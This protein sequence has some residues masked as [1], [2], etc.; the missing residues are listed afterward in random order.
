MISLPNG[1]LIP[2]DCGKNHTENYFPFE[3]AQEK[4]CETEEEELSESF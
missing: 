2:H 3:G 1:K 4:D